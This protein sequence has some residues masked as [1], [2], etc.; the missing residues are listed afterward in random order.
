MCVGDTVP[1]H[2]KDL[3]VVSL[4]R[5]LEQL[6]GSLQPFSDVVAVA[7]KLLRLLVVLHGCGGGQEGGGGVQVK[8]S[9]DVWG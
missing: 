4:A 8:V 6:A 7:V 5:E 2:S 9:A 3:V 1:A